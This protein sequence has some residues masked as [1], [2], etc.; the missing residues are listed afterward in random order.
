VVSDYLQ[1][2]L[3]R[4]LEEMRGT[5]WDTVSVLLVDDPQ[6][7]DEI[8]A[9]CRSG[10]ASDGIVVV[11]FDPLQLNH[12]ATDRDLD[13][14]VA[15]FGVQLHWLRACYRQKQVLGQLV[16]QLLD[17]LTASAPDLNHERFVRF[18]RERELIL[19]RTTGMDYVNPHGYV[20]VVEDFSA[21]DVQIQ[22]DRIRQEPHRLWAHWTNL[23]IAVDEGLSVPDGLNFAG[24]MTDVVDLASTEQVKGAEYQHAFLFLAAGTF[25][26]ISRGFRRGALDEFRRRRLLRIPLTRAK[27]SL[28]LFV[29]NQP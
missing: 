19:S 20:T 6:S 7:L 13:D 10:L 1:L 21:S 18:R 17:S 9:A 14:L 2:S 12:E 23:L 27:D 3:D 11:G 29:A 25:A 8:R 22:I 24:V 28:V 16:S 4:N 26:D 5:C 15:T